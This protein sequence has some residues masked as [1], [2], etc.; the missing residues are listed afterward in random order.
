MDYNGGRSVRNQGQ[1]YRERLKLL[2][3]TWKREDG[4]KLVV[5]EKM[6]IWL[7]AQRE[8]NRR[9]F[10]TLLIRSMSPAWARPS[11]ARRQLIN[12]LSLNFSGLSL[13]GN[14]CRWAPCQGHSPSSLASLEPNLQPWVWESLRWDQVAKCVRQ[15]SE[16]CKLLSQRRVAAAPK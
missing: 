16:L 5:K 13:G 12:S 7:S 8:W 1:L 3:R 11:I 14:Y 4:G 9:G 6:A 10:L 2:K 15:R